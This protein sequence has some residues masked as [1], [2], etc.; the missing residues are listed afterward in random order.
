MLELEKRSND[1]LAHKGNADAKQEKI[2]KEVRLILDRYRESAT[3]HLSGVPMI[4]VDM[5][6]FIRHDLRVFGVGVVIAIAL[7]LALIFHRVR[8][9]VLPLLTSFITIVLM[10]GILGFLKWPVTVVSSNFVS[11][12]LIFSTSLCVHLIVSY[13]ELAHDHPEASG[14][15]LVQGMIRDK[16]APCFFTILTTIV[17][18]GSLVVSGI[19][20]VVNFGWMMSIGL[21]IALVVSFT[22][23]PAMLLLLKRIS[24]DGYLD[25]TGRITE[26]CAQIV[27][28]HG[29]AILFGSGTL[30]VLCVYGMSLLTVDNRFI[31]YFKRSTEIFQG[32]EFIDNELGGTI[33]LDVILDAPA[34]FEPVEEDPFDEDFGEESEQ[35][36]TE[37]SYWFN[38]Y[39]LDYV[40]NVEEYLDGR[41]ETGKVLSLNTGLEV[42]RSL[43]DGENLQT[44]ELGVLYKRL[45]PDTKKTLVDP[46]LSDDGKQVRFSIRLNESMMQTNRDQ[47]LSDVRANLIKKFKFAPEEVRL[48]G[49]AVL[50]NNM[51]QSLFQSQILTLGVVL[52]AITVVFAFI[53]RSLY[54]AILSILPNALSAILVLGIM[55]IV[56]LPLDMMTITIA[57]ITVGIAVDDTIHY[58]HR[59]EHEI[60]EDGDYHF[61]LHRSHNTIGRAMYYT[62]ITIMIGFFILVFSNFNPTM[63]FGVLTGLAMFSALIA[64]LIL[65]PALLV[66]ARPYGK[67]KS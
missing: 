6:E 56:G 3:I 43:N 11:L 15:E 50:F 45:P 9:V 58:I 20:P 14:G 18:F 23:F 32:M 38:E 46:Y 13:Q 5:I 37:T 62:S 17:A 40:R 61:A 19:R 64:N 44:F 39:M 2:I 28:K 12:L 25:I 55:G 26:R 4:V 57:A 65:L 27:E 8:F 33:P 1:F 7:L 42:V 49:M 29:T 47:F 10:F 31:D 52:L 24:D 60:K 21:S 48:T 67:G 22:F 36:L 66:R 30:A 34:D 35:S 53:F 41:P 59:F 63:Y 51:L 16:F 54:V